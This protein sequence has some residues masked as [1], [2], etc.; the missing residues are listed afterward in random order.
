MPVMDGLQATAYVRAWEKALY[1]ESATHESV[2]LHI[3]IVLMTA[4]AMEGGR[5]PYLAG[6]M[7]GYISKPINSAELGQVIQ[8]AVANSSPV[9]ASK[10]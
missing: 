6:G 3:P 4:H 10:T 8:S 2:L 5:E 1:A 9:P 7:D